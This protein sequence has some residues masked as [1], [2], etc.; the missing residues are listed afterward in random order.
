MFLQL[1]ISDENNNNKQTEACA[2]PEYNYMSKNV[3][4]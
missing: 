1:R 2:K 3:L 4:F